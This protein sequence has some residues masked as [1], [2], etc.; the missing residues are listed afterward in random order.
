MGNKIMELMEKLA[1]KG[2]IAV[3]KAKDLAE[4]ARLK[5]QILSCEDV[6]KKNYQEIGKIVYEEYQDFPE[7]RMAEASYLKQCRAIANAKQGV[8]KLKAQIREI[9]KKS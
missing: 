3:N 2:N 9:Q 8:E 5:A 4:I 1:E 7:E 6:I